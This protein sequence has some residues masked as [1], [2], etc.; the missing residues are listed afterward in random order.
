MNNEKALCVRCACKISDLFG[1][2]ACQGVVESC[3]SLMNLEEKELKNQLSLGQ[4]EKLAGLNLFL[5]SET[6]RSL[7]ATKLVE[8]VREIT[9]VTFY[10][11]SRSKNYHLR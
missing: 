4:I 11:P 10:W 8:L 7:T 6:A 5:S 1:F 9:D 2:G 3:Q